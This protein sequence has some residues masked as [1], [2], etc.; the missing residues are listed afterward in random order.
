LDIQNAG[1]GGYH[2]GNFDNYEFVRIKLGRI[3]N[4]FQFLSI[5]QPQEK[6]NRIFQAKYHAFKINF[7]DTQPL[8]K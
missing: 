4:D 3:S 1:N 7:L 2:G 5:T 8:N 6:E